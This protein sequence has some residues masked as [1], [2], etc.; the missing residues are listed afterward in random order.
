MRKIQLIRGTDGFDQSHSKHE[1]LIN[2]YGV[3]TFSKS[4][5]ISNL[6]DLVS[7]IDMLVE[8]GYDKYLSG[9]RTELSMLEDV[10]SDT[11]HMRNL[12]V[13]NDDDKAKLEEEERVAYVT[14]ADI[15]VEIQFLETNEEYTRSLI[16]I[17]R[18]INKFNE[19]KNER[20]YSPKVLK[21]YSY[22]MKDEIKN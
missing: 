20:I 21:E 19:R 12:F 5:A 7:E 9:K 15:K 8:L 13:L 17:L 16:N 14:R 2:I 1:E 3:T 6:Y 10:I 4:Q 22:I 18:K 11:I